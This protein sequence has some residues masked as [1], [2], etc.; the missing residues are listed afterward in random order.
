MAKHGMRKKLFL[1]SLFFL[2]LLT[3]VIPNSL[4]L[5]SFAALSLTAILGVPFV[6]WTPEFTLLAKLYILS[7]LVT[8]VY[9]FVGLSG[10]APVEAAFQVLAVYIISPFLWIVAAA[11]LCA[12]SSDESVL[13]GVKILTV[14][15]VASVAVFFYLFLN[16]GPSAV[17]FLKESANVNVDDGYAGATMHV[18]GTLIFL[19]GGFFA[20][21]SVIVNPF[22]RFIFYLLLLVTCVTSGRSALILSA[23]IGFIVGLVLSDQKNKGAYRIKY[24]F[25]SGIF[26]IVFLFLAG[27]SDVNVA[28]ILNDF[29]GEIS[30]G[31]GEE[32]TQQMQALFHG[33]QQSNGLGVGHGIGVDY[34]R[35]YDY[36]WRYEL[37]WLATI[38][39]VGYVGAIVY[40]LTFFYGTLC[41]FRL[42]RRR[43]VKTLDLFLFGGF[44]SAFLAS[45]TNPYIEGFAFQWMYVLPIVFWSLRVK[46]GG[47]RQTP[48][49]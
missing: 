23:P 18:Y 39:R 29:F 37:V 15:C 17:S 6:T 42:Y 5:V 33:I 45:N 44:F 32:R 12:L 22:F 47:D 38:L 1:S 30:S 48:V 2:S 16:F 31:G 46:K 4:Q 40:S 25:F 21:G 24:I 27:F 36:P 11:G 43:S 13:Q 35:N 49:F 28:L 10:G 3:V 9:I 34:V 14:L 19:V 41:F 20:A 7:V 26:G 8:V